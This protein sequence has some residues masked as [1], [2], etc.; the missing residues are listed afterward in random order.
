[1]DRRVNAHIRLMQAV[2]V[3]TNNADQRCYSGVLAMHRAQKQLVEPPA[4]NRDASSPVAG[5]SATAAA[6]KLAAD[7]PNELPGNAPTSNLLLLRQV[8]TEPMFLMLLAAGSIYFALGDRTEALL[9]LGFVVLVIALT[10][11][12]QHKTQRTL[13]SLRDLSAPRA[14]VI[15]DQQTLRIAARDLV[16]GDIIILREGD[17]IAA[18]ATLLSGQ[19][20][21]NESLLTGEAMPVQK[22]T[23]QQHQD[24]SVPAAAVAGAAADVAADVSTLFASTVVVSGLGQ[25]VVHATAGATAVGQ[26]GKD[27][28]KS[29]IQPSAL[30]TASGQL[31]RRLGVLA[32]LI[33]LCQ[34]L[35][36]WGWDQQPLLPSLLSGI[37]LAMAILPEEIPV[38]LT[39]FLAMG[40]WRL[41]QQKVLT[42]RVAA[43]ESLGAVSVLAVDKTGT[44]TL[45]QMQVAALAIPT[46]QDSAEQFSPADAKSL[47]EAFHSLTE[48]AMLATPGDPFDP[49]EQA[50]QQFSDRWLAGTEHVRDG[51]QPEREYPLSADILAMTKVFAGNT[52]RQYVLAAKGAPEAI[53]DLCHLTPAQCGQIQTQV[54]A[55]AQ[56]GW[57]VLGVARGLWEQASGRD[58][59]WPESQHQFDFSFCGLVALADPPRPEVPAAIAECRQAG[60]RLLMLTGDHADTA[61]AIAAQIGLSERPE[62]LTGVDLAALDDTALSA[63]LHKTDICARLQPSDKLRLVTLLQQQGEVVA[64]TGD[65]VNDATA[66]KAADIGIA[67]GQRGTDVARE[68][69]ALVL[70]DDS[71]SRIVSAIRQGRRIYDNIGKATQFTFAVHMPIIALALVPALLHWPA[72]L[73]PVHIVLLE[74]IINPACSIIFEAEPGATDLMQRPPRDLH[75]SPF[76][77][78]QLGQGLLQG[79]GIAMILLGM[80][81]WLLARHGAGVRSSSLIVLM[82]LL[83]VFLLILAN[84][85][86][87]RPALSGLFSQN[88]WVMRLALIMI[89]LLGLLMW[90]RPLGAVMG[91]MAP[92]GADFMVAAVGIVLML[93]WL[94][95]LRRTSA[96]APAKPV[97]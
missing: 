75:T 19:L 36:A 60:I 91:T 34:V 35:L 57:R 27:L 88:R 69:A 45:N 95:L 38:I 61:R 67:M 8:L 44:L 93:L 74:L 87:S 58:S 59:G 65:G 18:D 42:R 31:V 86:R 14:L 92:A 28:A 41:A 9:L 53:A 71:F 26:I 13:E 62:V 96:V 80:Y 94:E 56:R 21:V 50:I 20:A 49:M 29:Q 82:L 17:R 23:R 32:L 37:A 52:P 79:A 46:G 81:G 77:L 12:E 10:W 73:L 64:M 24:A 43:V 51:R 39:V 1:M 33:A 66:L 84:R 3:A 4:L 90:L 76:S 54:H 70:L 5:L 83:S 7:G 63:R 47:P 48:F 89:L 68:A 40:A 25:A 11:L 30:Q 16:C 78:H 15:R 2:I 6:L 55:M 72:L 22:M 85:D 97:V